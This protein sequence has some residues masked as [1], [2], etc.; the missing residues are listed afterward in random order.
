VVVALVADLFFESKV[1]A[2]ATFAGTDVRVVRRTDQLVPLA[3]G[4]SGIILDLSELGT[5]GLSVVAELRAAAPQAEIVGFLSHVQTELAALARAAGV[6][7]V[8]PRSKFSSDLVA[9]LRELGQ[10]RGPQSAT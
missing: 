8:L 10:P 6:G 7:R 5:Q 9:I 3:A 2:A 4:A 1:L